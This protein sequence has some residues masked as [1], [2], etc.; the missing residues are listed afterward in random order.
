MSDLM[1]NI[2]F[3]DLFTKSQVRLYRYIV[4][5]VGNQTEAEDILQN[6]N[7]VLLEKRDS[8]EPGTNFMAWASSVAYLE[9]QKHRAAKRRITNLL[10]EAT[11]ELLAA[12]ARE[13]ASLLEQRFA[14]LPGC[15]EKL[16]PADLALI[17]DHYYHGLSWESIARSLG[18]TASSV[19]HSVCRIRR[20]LKRCIDKAVGVEEEVGP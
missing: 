8:Y 9:V 20:E 17:K 12:E 16:A 1:P 3:L 4:M 19:R 10:S 7:L 14:A 5:L 2:H 11:L 6:T 15:M 18:R 13:H